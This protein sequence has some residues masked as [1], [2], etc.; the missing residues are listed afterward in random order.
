MVYKLRG[1]SV[2]LGDSSS[3]AHLGSLHRSFKCIEMIELS[4]MDL[5]GRSSP[6]SHFGS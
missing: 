1:W 3:A 5:S 4:Y 6:V 2:H